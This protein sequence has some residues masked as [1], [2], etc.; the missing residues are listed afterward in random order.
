[1]RRSLSPGGPSRPLN[2][3]RR[4]RTDFTRPFPFLRAVLPVA[5]FF[6]AATGIARAD[7]IGHGGMVRALAVSADGSKVLTGSFDYSAR[8]WDFVEQ[9]ELGV[10]DEHTG[11]VNAVAFVGDGKRGLT[12]GNDGTV[13]LW[14]LDTLKPLRRLNGHQNRVMALAVAGGVAASGSWDRTVRIWDLDSGALVRTIRQPSPVNTIALGPGG[15]LLVVGGH[16]GI[17]RLWDVASG[18]PLGSLKGHEL[19]I[20]QVAVSPDG[21]YLLSSGIDNTLR[22]WDLAEYREVRSFAKHEKQI[23]GIAFSPDGKTALSTGRDGL[24]I[25]WDLET[26]DPIR[27]IRAHS[28]IAWAVAFS[29]DGRFALTASSDEVVRMWHLRSGDRIGISSAEDTSPKPWLTSTHPGARM[30]RKCALCH[31]LTPDGPKRT[32]P[33]FAG[34]FGRRAGS[35]NGY[36]Y[37]DALAGLDFEWN[38][39][40]L[41]TLFDKGP[42]VFLP[43]TK[44]PMQQVPDPEQLAR[45]ID[46]LKEIT[47]TGNSAD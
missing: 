46:Y 6:L 26:G 20:T 39:Q 31:S 43:G 1:M 27:T 28:R 13:I 4:L 32:G 2:G 19:G 29:P 17:V 8:L 45:L 12:A 34:L 14:D 21:K 30:F 7:F 3:E 35:V 22:L 42:D 37:S 40:T 9:K 41:R 25:H 36:R 24:L 10:L 5:A 15:G 38:D 44:M 47:A 11:P 16:D 18:R 23:Y 33:H